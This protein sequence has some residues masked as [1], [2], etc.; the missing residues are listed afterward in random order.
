MA[1]DTDREK[2]LQNLTA[3]E[4][5]C[6]KLILFLIGMIYPAKYDSQLD[7]FISSIKEEMIN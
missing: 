5:M 1:F 6:I 3:R 4:R 2:M 7:K